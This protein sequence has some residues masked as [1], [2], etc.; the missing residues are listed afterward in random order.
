[1]SEQIL[2]RVILSQELKLLL[3]LPVIPLKTKQLCHDFLH[4]PNVEKAQHLEGAC[5]FGV[6]KEVS[7][8]LPAESELS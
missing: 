4:Y 6:P 8:V 3:S 7:V 1:M 2:E 5:M